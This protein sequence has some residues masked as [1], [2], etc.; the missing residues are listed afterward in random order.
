MNP[1]KILPIQSI[2]VSSLSDKIIMK[3]VAVGRNSNNVHLS[4]ENFTI[5]RS[6]NNCLQIKNKG[7][8][9]EH[10]KISKNKSRW[11]ITNLSLRK[12][13]HNQLI[14][15]PRRSTTAGQ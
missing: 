6:K 15:L 4:R 8:S 10:L 1:I 5:G 9:R 3:L 11:E 14:T 7:I 12:K 2:H 13:H